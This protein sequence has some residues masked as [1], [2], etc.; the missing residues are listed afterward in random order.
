MIM[1]KIRK[2]SMGRQFSNPNFDWFEQEIIKH[3][4]GNAFKEFMSHYASMSLKECIYSK[5]NKKWKVKKYSSDYHWS[6]THTPNVYRER[7]WEKN[8][9]CNK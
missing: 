8:V 2:L 5:D 4:I 3:E 9:F 1:K 7:I 6:I